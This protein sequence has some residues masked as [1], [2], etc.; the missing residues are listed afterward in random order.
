[1]RLKPGEPIQLLDG[2]GGAWAA[3]I[4]A[5]ARDRVTVIVGDAL[6]GRSTRTY[7]WCSIRL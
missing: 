3:T 5:V 1:L 4:E 7:A 6:A 2:K